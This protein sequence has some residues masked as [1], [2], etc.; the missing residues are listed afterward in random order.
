MIVEL[1]VDQSTV[2]LCSRD[3]DRSLPLHVACRRG[4]SFA[5]VQ[6]LVDLY[7]ASVKTVPSEGDLTLFLACEMPETSQDTMFVLRKLYPELVYRR[8]LENRCR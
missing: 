4:V 6:S 2:L 8:S 1:L 5:V 7:E 3:Q